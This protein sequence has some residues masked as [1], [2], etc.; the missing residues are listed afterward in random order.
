MLRQA[1]HKDLIP[2]MK[3]SGIFCWREI[4]SHFKNLTGLFIDFQL[5]EKPESPKF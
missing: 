1:Q 2:D 3:V 5:F 4:L